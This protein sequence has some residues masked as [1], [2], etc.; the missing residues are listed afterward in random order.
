MMTQSPI[1]ES[2]NREGRITRKELEHDLHFLS[3]LQLDN[4]GNSPVYLASLPGSLLREVVHVL[5]NKLDRMEMA[6]FMASKEWVRYGFLNA[7]DV[8]GDPAC[9]GHGLNAVKTMIVTDKGRASN[10]TRSSRSAWSQ[11][12]LAD[13]ATKKEQYEADFDKAYEAYCEDL[14]ELKNLCAPLVDIPKFPVYRPDMDYEPLNTDPEFYDNWAYDRKVEFAE[15]SMNRMAEVYIHGIDLI[16]L[17]LPGR[18]F[19]RIF[20]RMC[21]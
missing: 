9:G 3:Y 4:P 7:R 11:S 5:L 21:F 1:E 2:R 18:T 20:S 14:N 13:E 10:A 15:T 17:W 8:L 12:A 16:L 6:M 19:L